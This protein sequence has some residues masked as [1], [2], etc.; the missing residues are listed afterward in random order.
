V[1]LFVFQVYAVSFTQ[2]NFFVEGKIAFRVLQVYVDK[3]I[4]PPGRLT[5][6]LHVCN[7][8]RCGEY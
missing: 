1:V 6:C 8:V 3:Y 4:S 2:D 7:D 5:L